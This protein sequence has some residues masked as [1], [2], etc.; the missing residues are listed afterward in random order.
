MLLPKC[1]PQIRQPQLR[2]STRT[3]AVSIVRFAY[4]I[5]RFDAS[6]ISAFKYSID[7]VM[8]SVIEANVAIICS[9]FLHF[10]LVKPWLIKLLKCSEFTN[11][12]VQRIL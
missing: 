8:C 1:P 6:E 12:K 11:P 7:A 4:L 3:T 9:S 5:E 10:P 2:V